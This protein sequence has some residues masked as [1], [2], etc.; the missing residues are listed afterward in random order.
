MLSEKERQIFY[1]FVRHH[2]LKNSPIGSKY[3]SKKINYK[4]SAPLLR[5]YFRKLTQKGLL[6]SKIQGRYPSDKGWKYYLTQYEIKPE[7]KINGENLKLLIK[8]F[9]K[10]AKNSLII[11]DK[12]RGIKIKGLHFLAEGL[13]KET[14][15]DALLLIEDIEKEIYRL[16]NKIGVK[17][18]KEIEI[19]RTKNLSLGYTKG[20]NKLYLF[21]GPK[22]NYYH[23]LWSI[24]NKINEKINE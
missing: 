17:I 21:L 13:E 18:G 4:F 11:F 19:S 8:K 20:K 14:L 12:S 24:L 15:C 9:L 23:T 22:R 2:L 7:I 1:L 16:E 3:L 5:F 6:F 10:L